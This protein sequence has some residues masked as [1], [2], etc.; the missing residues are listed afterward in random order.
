[1]PSP[2]PPPHEEG[3]LQPSYVTQ[4]TGSHSPCSEDNDLGGGGGYEMD[5]SYQQKME[6]EFEADF[7]QFGMD[8][9]GETGE[10]VPADPRVTDPAAM[11]EAPVLIFEGGYYSSTILSLCT[12]QPVTEDEADEHG[13]SSD[14][15]EGSRRVEGQEEEEE[16][17]EGEGEG[18]PGKEEGEGEGGGVRKEEKE[19]GKDVEEGEVSDSSGEGGQTKEVR[20]GQWWTEGRVRLR[21]VV[22]SPGSLSEWNGRHIL[23]PTGQAS[24]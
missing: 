23:Q 10:V 4:E 13:V 14:R 24:R 22:S 8:E 7:Q 12:D 17:E 11:S 3:S 1:M 5:V 19:E 2:S 6:A 9:V 16:G 18:E 21:L 20:E 15:G